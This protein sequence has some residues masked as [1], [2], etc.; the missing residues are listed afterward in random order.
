MTFRRLSAFFLVAAAVAAYA[1]P[2]LADDPTAAALAAIGQAGAA[3]GG[4][5]GAQGGKKKEEGGFARKLEAPHI[6]KTAD[7][8][9]ERPTSKKSSA[10]KT[11]PSKYRSTELSESVEHSY[12]FNADAEPLDP[13]PKKKPAAKPKKKTSAASDDD[14]EK[15]AACSSDESC[16]AKKSDSDAF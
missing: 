7:G 3:G 6:E 15:A 11:K 5:P 2:A 4:A 8:N 1:R 12:H 16:D 13:A 9:Q 14:N 10:A